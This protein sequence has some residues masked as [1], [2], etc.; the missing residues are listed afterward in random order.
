[1][2]GQPYALAVNDGPNT[3]HGGL[4]GFDKQVWA[5]KEIDGDNGKALELTY[6]SPDG[7]EGYPGNLTV[8]Y[9]QVAQKRF[10]DGTERT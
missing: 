6:L 1:M 9:G 4:K 10:F 2:D 8:P 7:E 3:L 5:A